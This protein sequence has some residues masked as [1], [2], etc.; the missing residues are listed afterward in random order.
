MNL[1][2]SAVLILI[3]SKNRIILTKRTK[4]VRT[5]KG[6]ISFPGGKY[7]DIDR[8]LIITAIRETTEE[9]G[10]TQDKIT[11][12]KKLNYS[13]ISPRGFIIYPFYAKLKKNSFKKN[14]DEVEKIIKIPVA[15]FK[16]GIYSKHLYKVNRKKVLLPVYIFGKTRI[17][18]ATANIIYN[19]IRKKLNR[20][21][22]YNI[23][24]R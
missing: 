19:F 24:N 12:I 23:N 9:I 18:G 7:E 13:Y 2:S 21:E 16:K 11:E 22:F 1:R 10:V 6:Q 17:W 20:K 4:N 5:H 8:E 14:S 15:F 3:D